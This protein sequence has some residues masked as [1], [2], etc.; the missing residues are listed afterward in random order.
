MSLKKV[1]RRGNGLHRRKVEVLS[2]VSMLL[3]NWLFWSNTAAIAVEPIFKDLLPQV[4]CDP[5]CYGPLPPV[6]C[7]PFC[8]DLLPP[9][10]YG[11][12]YCGLL[13]IQ[14]LRHLRGKL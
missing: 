11:P 3:A 2:V 10:R 14:F 6:H 12:S 5:F 8:Y 9:V 13:A 4:R 1:V 7:D